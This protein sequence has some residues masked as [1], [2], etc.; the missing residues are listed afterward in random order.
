MVVRLDAFLIKHPISVFRARIFWKFNEILMLVKFDNLNK[1]VHMKI[2]VLS[3]FLPG[4]KFLCFF[5]YYKYTFWSHFFAEVLA[6]WKT[7][8]RAVF[9]SSFPLRFPKMFLWIVIALDTLFNSIMHKYFSNYNF[10]SFKAV[11][12]IETLGRL[13]FCTFSQ[14]FVLQFKMVAVLFFSSKYVEWSCLLRWL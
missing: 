11:A 13:I 6:F 10:S 12:K 14:I 1:F 7:Q 4:Y 9:I 5:L 3:L 8:S 2:V